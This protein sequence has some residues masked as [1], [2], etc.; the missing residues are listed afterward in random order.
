MAGGSRAARR[1]IGG[2]TW[3]GTSKH[4]GRGVADTAIEPA[5]DKHKAVLSALARYAEW[6]TAGETYPSLH[7]VMTQKVSQVVENSAQPKSLR[8]LGVSSHTLM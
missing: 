6:W 8:W 5:R 4:E 1:G 2:V 3:H 7:E